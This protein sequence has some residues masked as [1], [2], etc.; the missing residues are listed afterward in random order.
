MQVENGELCVVMA[1]SSDVDIFNVALEKKESISFCLSLVRNKLFFFFFKTT[2]SFLLS[3]S[4]P[5]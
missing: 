3:L 1:I 2:S 4:S 5:C